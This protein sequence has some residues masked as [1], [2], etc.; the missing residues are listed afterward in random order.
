LQPQKP[1]VVELA[2]LDK[3]KPANQPGCPCCGRLHKHCICCIAFLLQTKLAPSLKASS[4][5]QVQRWY[6][7]LLQQQPHRYSQAAAATA[8]AQLQLMLQKSC[9]CG[10]LLL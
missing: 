6:Q 8:M 9:C 2:H 7:V 3:Q 5:C 1:I 10:L 4:N